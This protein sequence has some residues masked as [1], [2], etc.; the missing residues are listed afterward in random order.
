MANSRSSSKPTPSASFTERWLL[1]GPGPPKNRRRNP[2]WR[3]RRFLLLVALFGMGVVLGGVTLLAQEPLPP[4]DD[5]FV[6]LKQTTYVCTAE[7][8]NN[9]S[10]DV[11]ALALSAGENRQI[12][13]YEEIPP[14][15]VNAV[16]AAEDKDYFSHRGL[17]PA[18]IGR[19]LYQ[20][21]RE[22]NTNQGGSTITQQYV[23]N[24]FLTSDR[25][26]VRKLKEATLAVKLDQQLS[27]E[28]ILER[29]LN[30]IYFGRGAYGIQAAAQSY[31]AKNVDELDIADSAYLA[32]L[33]RSP[34][35]A[36]AI[37][38]PEEATRRRA[39]VLAR[40]VAD[41]YISQPQA[42]EA[43]ARD[44][45]SVVDGK[46][47]EDTPT[48]AGS[49]DGSD[50]F[51]EAVRQQLVELENNGNGGLKGE[52]YTAGWRVYT[53]LDPQLQSAAFESVTEV[54]DPRVNPEDPSASL[55][56]LDR[57][58]R[59]VAMV[60]G[61][62]FTSSQVNLALGRE[63]GGSGRQPGSAFK[64][65]ALAEAIEQGISAESLYPAPSVIEIPGANNGGT[66]TVRGGS[67]PDGYR[68][69]IDAL[70]GSSNVVYAQLMVDVGSQSVVELANRLGVSAH[71]DPVNALVLGSGE[72][73]VLDMAS[74]YSTIANGGIAQPPVLIER[75]EDSKGVVRCWYP[76]DG[77]CQEFGAR[78]GQ[79][80]LDPAIARQVT[81]A[82][83][84]V[85]EAGTGRGVREFFD[86]PAAGKTGT[87]QD[88]RDAW[89]VGFT[90]ELTAAVWMGYPGAP[91]EAPRF[92]T[93]VRGIEVQG[94]NLPTDIWGSFMAQASRITLD[95]SQASCAGL[96]LQTEFPGKRLNTELSTT[97]LPPCAP[98]LVTEPPAV[99][100]EGDALATTVPEETT[101]TEP[102]EFVDPDPS[103][104]TTTPEELGEPSTSQS[105]TTQTTASG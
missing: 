76:V 70:R 14:V 103:Q 56:A 29:Y 43:N 81:Y 35:T 74:A 65:F 40:M 4:L 51:L 41:G 71:L 94:G 27:K 85:V 77:K 92:M 47:G 80:V 105:T 57:Q 8:D 34:S 89:F 60:G 96:N 53:T 104:T 87:T 91:G 72:V 2:L 59:V 17:D 33:I 21:I 95:R 68:D 98:I 82:L 66:W 38:D 36:D 48:L 11:A 61:F 88:S 83:S 12:V 54:V 37:R 39:T 99:G 20:D 90:C 64:T 32:G 93:D 63:G 69:L 16:V 15:L 86:Q 55:L 84:R 24:A 79:L 13:A 19:A 9:C 42:D 22:G 58:G 97:T 23:K 18:G 49:P 102:C 67:S 73:S 10:A 30:L 50:Y 100:E 52:V 31:F 78:L 7:I 46:R 45:S 62:D 1:S 6:E 44:W 5:P 75:I 25:T 28:E 26:L 101:T 3:F